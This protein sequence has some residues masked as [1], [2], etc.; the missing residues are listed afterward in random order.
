M[1]DPI[2]RNRVREIFEAACDVPP[3][4]QASFVKSA[5]A[6]D[7]A[8]R[9]EVMSLLRF[10]AMSGTDDQLREALRPDP[11]AI[12]HPDRIGPYE[13]LNPIGE[14]GCGIVYRARQSE[15]IRR[16]VAVKLI[17]P[18]MDSTSVLRRFELERQALQRMD[19][20]NIARVLDSGLVPS[21]QAGAQ[22][23]Y[24]VMELVDGMRI[25]EY[26]RCESLGLRDRIRLVLQVCAAVQH[27]HSKGIIHRDLKPSNVLVKTIDGQPVCK[28]IDF[29]VAKALGETDHDIT[30]MTSPGAM[31]G[32]P[33][34]MSPEQ[35][36]GSADIDT[37][38]D[39]YAL[40]IILY[41]LLA[42]VSPFDEGTW[43]GLGLA[44]MLRQIETTEPQTPSSR[45]EA[46]RSASV[47]R[48]AE[49][50]Q[51]ATHVLGRV[52]RDLDW[53]TLRAMSKDPNRRYP[54]VAALGD[55]LARYLS[56]EPVAAGPPT[57]SYKL[58]KF[59]SRNRALVVASVIAGVGVL[60]GSGASVWFGVQ[61][62]R[63]R[64][65]EA[66]Q[67][68]LAERKEAR[69]QA[70]NDFL[71]KDLFKA[72]SVTRLGPSATLVELLDQAAPTI[73]ERFAGDIDMRAQA[74]YLI[75]S[76]YN[77]TERYPRAIAHLNTA[78]GMMDE[79]EEWTELDRSTAYHTRA[80]A[81]LGYGL[82]D[83]AIED[84][85]ASLGVLDAMP[86]PDEG[87]RQ[88]RL[89]GLGAVYQA[90]EKYDLAEP[91]LAEATDHALRTDPL[92]VEWLT[93]TTAIRLAML[94]NLG[95]HEERV[96]LAEWLRGFSDE[97]D[98]PSSTLVADMHRIDSLA[99]LGQA[100]EVLDQ[101]ILMIDSVREVYSEHS[102]AYAAANQIAAKT[103]WRVGRAD[104]A[105]EYQKQ[106]IAT[107]ALVYGDHH[108]EVERSTN[109]LATYYK[110][111]GHTAEYVTARTRGLLLRLYV[112]GPGEHESLTAITPLG[113]ELVGSA[114]AWTQ[115]VLDEIE[116]LPKDHDKRA[117]FMANAAIALGARNPDT[118][119][120][121]R[122]GSEHT[123]STILIRAAESMPA[124]ERP[125]EVRRILLA[126]LPPLLERLGRPEEADQW[127][128]KLSAMDGH[129]G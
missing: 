12:D 104:E 4:Q 86:E 96:E 110:D 88:A 30:V 51:R 18:G 60:S 109:S 94:A 97:H 65:L 82:L 90:Q 57:V 120:V 63:A 112:A 98:E 61:A 28:V 9:A 105:I 73:D 10:D 14:G 24:F 56:G 58:S 21:G 50:H 53:V 116:Q 91:L 33:Q 52:P 123:L 71:L 93:K 89:T 59:V 107:M 55:D 43:R 7:E 124:A 127:Q 48:A 100:N 29:G 85:E 125:H 62:E 37:R 83:E 119:D 47:E 5:S 22:R 45:A 70:I 115:I 129:A 26:A 114:E 46:T 32:T 13:I 77:Q 113:I 99:Q 39:V 64:A 81:S 25:T 76:M 95:H 79:C 84:F 27:A 108:Y 118:P 3:E 31:V 128:R 111:R 38:T 78:I 11:A 121:L 23:P 72:S 35:M 8:M 2:D 92:D 36:R 17:K 106:T 20:P 67:R 69:Y 68:I 41:E 40:G 66:E 54:T 19:H 101:S 87:E 102:Q 6:G 80:V 122:P 1:T 34:Y 44:E 103:C 126:T 16:D 74:H 42:G 117:R 15:P 75:G 49:G